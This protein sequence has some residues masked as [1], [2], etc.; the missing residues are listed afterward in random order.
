LSFLGTEKYLFTPYFRGQ[1]DDQETHKI[2]F[3]II[4]SFIISKASDTLLCAKTSSRL[5]RAQRNPTKSGAGQVALRLY[6]F[7]LVFLS[8]Y[9]NY[10]DLR[11]FVS[12]LLYGFC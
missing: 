8:L 7:L 9:P 10:F 5:G 2:I 12:I 11:L 1:E 3:L 6:S 4:Y